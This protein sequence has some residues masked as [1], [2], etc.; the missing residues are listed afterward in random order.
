M[1]KKSRLCALALLVVSLCFSACTRRTPVSTYEVDASARRT[2]AQGALVGVRGSYGN[3][4][5]LGI[6]YAAPPI[7]ALRWRAP[8]AAARWSGDYP[9]TAL[10]PPCPQ[11]ASPFGGI[12]D[13]PAGT[14]AGDEDCLY[15]NVYTPGEAQPA[16]LPVMVWIHGGG[17]V[18]GHTGF[19][20]G[21]NLAESEKVVVVTVQYRLGPL[22]WFHHPALHEGATQAER[23]GNFGT[24]DLIHAL[25]WV[26]DN[27]AV[28][29]GDAGRVTIFGES[30]GARNVFSLLLSPLAR[31]LFHGAIAQSGAT[32]I[33]SPEQAYELAGTAASN[34]G[35]SSQEAVVALLLGDGAEGRAAA[36]SAMHSMSA[37]S[38]ND[39]L[40]AKS[41][42]ELLGAYRSDRGEGL[43]HVAN[44]FGDGTVIS[45]GDP[46]ANLAAGN[47]ADV[48]AIL[49][50]NRDEQKVF[51]FANPKWTKRL[52]GIL[53][54]QRDADLYNATAEVL[55]RMWVVRGAI[56]PAEARATAATARTYVYRW[57]WDEEPSI[58]G[59]HLPEMVGAAHGFEIPFVFGHFDLGPEGNVIFTAA[60]QPG[61]IELSKA[62]MSYWANF[63]RTGDP[64][65]GTSG[66]LPQWRAWRAGGGK[67]LVL[68]TEAGGGIRETGEA[69]S[70]ESILAGLD[71]DPRLATTE[72]RCAVYRELME[73]TQEID[74]TKYRA[75]GCR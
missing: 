64:G 18:I 35:G 11:I 68:D 2:I 71:S 51:M 37:Q 48:P 5:W 63:A 62:M 30:A 43:I 26:R 3:L 69:P 58:L 74:E 39:Y 33:P 50:T 73:W 40:R 42:G 57:D 72:R 13:Q 19:Y 4:A 61:R 54:R 47:A 41:A 7:G 60:N 52:F 1:I 45:A 22:G 31:G 17:N 28:F 66:T 70:R 67:R 65:R 46:L 6:P 23:S 34:V 29:G 14:T 9:A 12:V 36:I 49:G 38:L 75:A 20:D 59:S 32:Y 53:P 27:I 15:L 21:G 8:R 25:E 55:S 44:V 56:D 24:L 10:P 16:P